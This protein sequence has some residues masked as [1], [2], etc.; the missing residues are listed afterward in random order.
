[1]DSDGDEIDYDVNETKDASGPDGPTS[2]YYVWYAVNIDV[3]PA[4]PEDTLNISCHCL[5]SRRLL[6]VAYS[7]T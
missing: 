5:V 2:N 6:S 4:E 1:M 3:L 7:Q